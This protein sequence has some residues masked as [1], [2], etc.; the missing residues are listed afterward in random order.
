MIEENEFMQTFD[1]WVNKFATFV[2]QKDKVPPNKYGLM[3]MFYQVIYGQI[4]RMVFIIL[5]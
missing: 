2:Q 3:V 4:K 5:R 1:E